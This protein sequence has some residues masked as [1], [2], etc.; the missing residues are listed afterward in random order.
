MLVKLDALFEGV[1]G[2]VLLVT[3]A[4]G[5]LDGSDFPSPVGTAFLLVV[6]WA[7]LVLCGL[8]WIGRV[9]KGALALGNGVSALL[10]V[11]WLVAAD[12]WSSAGVALVVATIVVLA[13]LAAAQAVSLRT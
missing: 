8:I 9:G 7:L 6:G 13:V 1:L 10:G 5:A 12:G 2:I 3:A 4:T 11:A